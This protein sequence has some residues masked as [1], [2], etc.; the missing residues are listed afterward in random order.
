MNNS[1]IP[2]RELRLAIVVTD[3]N[4]C[5]RLRISDDIAS[6]GFR[7]EELTELR[8]AFAHFP[9]AKLK[10]GIGRPISHYMIRLSDLQQ[11]ALR[12]NIFYEEFISFFN[13]QEVSHET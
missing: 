6:W 3:I 8:D 2:I 1:P 11:G 7:Q 5:M 9:V 12:N 13:H 10:V 4:F